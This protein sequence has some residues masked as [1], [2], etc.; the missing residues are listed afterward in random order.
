M[1]SDYCGEI[2]DKF[3]G[4]EVKVCGWVHRRRDH[5]GLIFLDLRDVSGIVQLVINPEIGES[6]KKAEQVRS[7]YVLQAVGKVN[8]RPDDAEN[9][10]L[11][12]GSIEI[13]VDEL[14][15]LNA[16]ETP[17]FPDNYTEVGEEVRL[18]PYLDLRRETMQQNIKTRSKLQ[19]TLE[20]IL[21]KIIFSILKLQ[22]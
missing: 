16:A 3:I 10:A 11:T 13:I 2:N 12:T 22:Y 8:D 7:E 15:V 21:R 20:T 4:K 19:I 9:L 18:K 5:G 17:A 6:F 1:R 14:N